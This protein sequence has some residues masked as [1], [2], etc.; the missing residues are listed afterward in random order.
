MTVQL[1]AAIGLLGA[2]LMFSGDMLLYFTKGE[3]KMDGTLKPYINIM[4]KLPPW[5][6]RFGGLLGPFAAFFYCI[7]FYQM[8]LATINDFRPFAIAATILCSLG[9]II[10]GA[11]H[12]HFTYLGYVGKA[13]NTEIEKS[14]LKN[15]LFL[16]KI[17]IIPIAFGILIFAGLVVFGKTCY[18]WWFLFFTPIVLIFLSNL[19]LKLPQPL[20][21]I[22]FGGWNNIVFIIYFMAAMIF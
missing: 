16:S 12:S 15:I 22:M 17:S 4:S 1:T 21:V 10:G 13:A 5:R 20:H 2:I 11:Y 7:G 8:T 6:L 3:F 18:P 14:I 9:I 19:W